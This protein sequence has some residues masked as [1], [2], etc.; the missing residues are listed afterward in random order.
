MKYMDPIP[1]I[2]IHFGNFVNITQ[3]NK[4]VEFCVSYLVLWT[5]PWGLF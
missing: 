2:C 1:V 4:V 5:G 3:N